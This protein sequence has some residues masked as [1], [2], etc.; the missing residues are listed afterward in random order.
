MRDEAENF[1][2]QL[3]ALPQGPQCVLQR[4]DGMVHGFA[5]M[6]TASPA[7]RQH[8][9]GACRMLEQLRTS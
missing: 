6:L 5:R 1:A 4:A 7:A 3:Q 2:H 8:V 9:E